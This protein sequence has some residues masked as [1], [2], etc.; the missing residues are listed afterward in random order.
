MDTHRQP[1][2][3]NARE[4]GRRI[5][6][7]DSSAG[8]REREYVIFLVM[9]AGFGAR[10]NV[11]RIAQIR[12]NGRNS[13]IRFYGG[14][15]AMAA[16]SYVRDCSRRIWANLPLNR[17]VVL[18]RVRKTIVDANAGGTR[19]GF[20]ERPVNVLV[21]DRRDREWEVLSINLASH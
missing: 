4:A 19:N 17:E 8:V 3:E 6:V 9:T 2:S 13:R 12:A 18:I 20:K 14:R 15:K 16:R 7:A 5:R 1:S 21:A 10:L 11:R